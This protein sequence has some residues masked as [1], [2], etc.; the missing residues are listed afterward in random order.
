M[1]LELSSPWFKLG[2]EFNHLYFIKT[3]PKDCRFEALI[4]RRGQ[5]LI[6]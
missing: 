3:E 2:F 4:K 6:R 1:H 5:A